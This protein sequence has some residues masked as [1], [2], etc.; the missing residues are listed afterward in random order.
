ME[1][2]VSAHLASI[3]DPRRFSQG[4]QP[5]PYLRQGP[6]PAR[7]LEVEI[8]IHGKLYGKRMS[9]QTKGAEIMD[10]NV[11]LPGRLVGAIF[12]LLALLPATGAWSHESE[13]LAWN[14]AT[15]ENTL[16]AYHVYL[17]AHPA[18]RHV[19]DAKTAI[20]RVFRTLQVP[21]FKS[22]SFTD[23]KIT[24]TSRFKTEDGKEHVHHSS[25]TGTQE[26]L[27]LRSEDGQ[28]KASL[29]DIC[30]LSNRPFFCGDLAVSSSQMLRKPLVISIAE[31]HGTIAIPVAKL[32][33][34][35]SSTV[36]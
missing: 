35:F 16:D 11:V 4:Q 7:M 31:I 5:P 17:H 36:N 32:R 20:D 29:V 33:F 30:L 1:L 27:L 15:D 14:K 24:V 8:T 28:L 19:A 25:L 21:D 10:P 18:G 23:L 26:A 3:L 9:H 6:R 2:V 12:I 13:D 22:L 34:R